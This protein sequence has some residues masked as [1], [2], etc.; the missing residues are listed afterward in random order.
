MN[1]PTKISARPQ[2]QEFD[3]V[4]VKRNP[5]TSHL[6]QADPDWKTLK[7]GDKGAIMM[8]YDGRDGF[9]YELDVPQKGITVNI[10]EKYLKVD[11]AHP[12]PKPQ[13][14]LINASKKLPN[15]PESVKKMSR[16][17]DQD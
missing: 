2:F 11:R 15:M 16:E 13:I 10:E 4:V 9:S 17:L 5:Q 8:V 14:E 1:E 12:L 6:V 3:C 7:K